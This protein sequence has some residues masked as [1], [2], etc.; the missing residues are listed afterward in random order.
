[1]SE[2]EFWHLTLREFDALA[3]CWHD[4]RRT[5]QHITDLHFATLLCQVANLNRAKGHRAYDVEDFLILGKA[6]AKRQ[7]PRKQ[8]V[9]PVQ[10]V[11]DMK[12]IAEG[13][14]IGLGG[15]ITQREPIDGGR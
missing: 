5:D 8:S 10:T 14:T 15:K 2:A 3:E 7:A 1:M 13:F 6:G 4:T 9:K 12:R 11:E